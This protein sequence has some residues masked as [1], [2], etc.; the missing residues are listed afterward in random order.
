LPAT[1]AS[2][3]SKLADQLRLEQRDALGNIFNKDGTLTADALSSSSEIMDG[4]KIRNRDVTD[5]MTADGSSLGDWGKYETERLYPEMG[6]G[7]VHFYYNPVT[8]KVL[9][10]FDYKF[11]LDTPKGGW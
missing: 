9:Y 10:E 3:A 2:A 7:K 8:G 6:P 5:A 4:T 1:S 11:K